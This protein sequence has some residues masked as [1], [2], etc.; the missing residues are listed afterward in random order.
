MSVIPIAETMVQKQ[1]ICCRALL[2][3]LV[4]RMEFCIRYITYSF[5]VTG[6]AL[7]NDLTSSFMVS[8]LNLQL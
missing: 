1:R 3:P 2:L 7:G 6:L 5:M 4:Q 8:H